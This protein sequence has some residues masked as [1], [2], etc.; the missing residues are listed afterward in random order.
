MDNDDPLLTERAFRVGAEPDA[1]AI[2]GIGQSVCPYSEMSER[3]LQ[4]FPRPYPNF[5]SL[6]LRVPPEVPLVVRESAAR[7]GA[8]VASEPQPGTTGPS[9]RAPAPRGPT[10]RERGG[11]VPVRHPSCQKA[12]Q[13]MKRR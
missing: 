6:S 4:T 10:V 8:H 9:R 3:W 11:K 5:S 12:G 13:P 7:K 2:S 1:Q